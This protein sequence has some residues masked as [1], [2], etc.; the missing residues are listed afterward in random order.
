MKQVIIEE[1]VFDTNKVEFTSK[2]LANVRINL[3][4]IIVSNYSVVCIDQPHLGWG[5]CS[6]NFWWYLKVQESVL[7]TKYTS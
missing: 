6:M 4:I 3:L 2:Q 1:L 5:R 7:K